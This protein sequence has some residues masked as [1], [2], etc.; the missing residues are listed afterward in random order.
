VRATATLVL[1]GH[2]GRTG[3]LVTCLVEVVS[4]WV[5]RSCVLQRF[6]IFSYLFILCFS[7]YSQQRT[8]TCEN[9]VAG[10]DGCLG[11]S[12]NSEDCNTGICGSWGEWGEFSVCNVACGGGTQVRERKCVVASNSGTK[13]LYLYRLPFCFVANGNAL[14]EMLMTRSKSENPACIFDS[15]VLLG[16]VRLLKTSVNL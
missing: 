10:K 1:L 7:K 5:A 3:V 8:R 4:G 2:P 11:P 13:S 15:N 9:G 16:M 6:Y 12:T 14:T